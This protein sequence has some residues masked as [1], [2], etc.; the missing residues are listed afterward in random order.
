MK[1]KSLSFIGTVALSFSLLLSG[2]GS[3]SDSSS[4][5]AKSAGGDAYYAAEN[6][7]YE[8]A[9]SEDYAASQAEGDVETETDVEVDESSQATD[10]K[11]ITTVYINSETLSFDETISWVEAR[12]LELGGYVESSSISVSGS[13]YYSDRYVDLHTA[14]YVIR[15]PEQKLEG[16]LTDVDSK[17]NITY[18]SKNVEDVTLTYTDIVAHQD[19]LE[20]EKEALEKLMDK[21]ENMEDIITIQTELTDVQYQ[22]DS[23]KSQL[24]VYDNKIDYSTINISIKEVE[25]DNLT[26]TEKK[27]VFQRIGDGFMSSLKGTGNFLVELFIVI[28]V[29]IPQLI[30]LAAI[31]I[32][33]VLIAKKNKK[34]SKKDKNKKKSGVFSRKDISDPIDAVNSQEGDNY[35]NDSDGQK[36]KK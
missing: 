15:I 36:D 8:V 5:N 24:R 28:V 32:V 19:A 21:A 33:I 23:I 9:M 27:T 11:L 25:P 16:F 2:C 4:Y 22:I 13:Y 30:L 34:S 10:R 6:A 12:T 29:N 18:K 35:Q 26:I 14:D 3:S 1:K 17:T 31:I 20:A 7:N